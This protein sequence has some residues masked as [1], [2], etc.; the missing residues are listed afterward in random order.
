MN[1]ALALGNRLRSQVVAWTSEIEL[2]EDG[3]VDQDDGVVDESGE[4]LKSTP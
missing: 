1:R 3:A 2:E 4:G